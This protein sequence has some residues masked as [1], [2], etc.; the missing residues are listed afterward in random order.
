MKLSHLAS[1]VAAAA[2]ALASW[3][4]TAAAESA[5]V[6]ASPNTDRVETIGPNR[7]L[8]GSGIWTL[9]LSYVPAVVVA[10][11]SDLPADD[12]LF[13]PVAG[14]WLDYGTRDCPECNHETLNKVLLVTD[15]VFQGIGALQIVGSFLFL[16]TR[17]TQ[18][19]SGRPTST[20]TAESARPPLRIVPARLASGYGLTA[21]G[22]F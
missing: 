10:V 2:L 8:L 12:N 21:R 18:A 13:I 6:V 11:E 4:G 17:T 5:R 9:G 19:S 3:S 15:G 20:A 14:P 7:K 1:P 16:E 22:Y